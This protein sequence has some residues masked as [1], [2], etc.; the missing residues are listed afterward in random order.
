LEILQMT[1]RIDREE[2]KIIEEINFKYKA[3]FI[4]YKDFEMKIN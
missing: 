2:R 1:Y 4:I 3:I